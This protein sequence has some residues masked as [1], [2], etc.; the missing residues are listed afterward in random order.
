[1]AR[2]NEA[3]P[4]YT[5]CVDSGGNG[6]GGGDAARPDPVKCKSSFPGLEN[7]GLL[8]VFGRSLAYV[9]VAAS[10]GSFECANISSAKVRPS[11]TFYA[12]RIPLPL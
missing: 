5:M 7:N 12:V 3:D 10:S 4:W 11:M 6:G 2:L 9:P 8:R 1:M